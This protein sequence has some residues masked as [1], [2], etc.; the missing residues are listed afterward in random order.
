LHIIVCPQSQIIQKDD[1]AN[2]GDESRSHEPPRD[3]TGQSKG[4]YL[5]Y[6]QKEYQPGLESREG[7]NQE[8]IRRRELHPDEDDQQRTDDV[9]KIEILLQQHT[10]QS[11]NTPVL[12]KW[13]TDEQYP[14][15]YAL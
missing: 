6:G 4:N 7:P 9:W 8:E 11:R 15:R 5:S 10:Y 14:E 2:D 13:N 3:G 12:G 1:A